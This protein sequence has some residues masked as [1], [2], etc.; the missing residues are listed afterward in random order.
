MCAH[1]TARIQR[2]EHV[3][4]QVKAVTFDEY[5][6]RQSTLDELTARGGGVCVGKRGEWK[7]IA[8]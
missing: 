4:T 3:H 5:R 1:R 8:M 7:D 6:R 2:H